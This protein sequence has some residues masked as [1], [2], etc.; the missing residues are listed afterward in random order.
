[1][2]SSF[3]KDIK[4]TNQSYEQ[5]FINDLHLE[6]KKIKSNKKLN[7]SDLYFK[8]HQLNKKISFL[9]EKLDY[10]NQKV[11]ILKKEMSQKLES[12]HSK[13][14]RF[15]KRLFVAIAVL[16]ALAITMLILE[17]FVLGK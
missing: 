5:Y 6:L 9:N 11:C 3:N 1:M 15:H 10:L 17:F 14:K 8:I 12:I 13:V 7:V 16:S 2:A 4:N